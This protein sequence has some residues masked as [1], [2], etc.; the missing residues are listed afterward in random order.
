MVLHKVKYS[1]MSNATNIHSSYR[2]RDLLFYQNSMCSSSTQ[3]YI[4]T[5]YSIY[6]IINVCCLVEE[7]LCTFKIVIFSLCTSV[8]ETDTFGIVY[9]NQSQ[10]TNMKVQMYEHI[11]FRQPCTAHNIR[12]LQICLLRSQL[13]QR[14]RI[15]LSFSFLTFVKTSLNLF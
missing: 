6:H 4:S 1:V 9:I 15:I 7:F 3:Y 11:C 5:L 10:G 2:N 13:K 12:L 14:L 8:L